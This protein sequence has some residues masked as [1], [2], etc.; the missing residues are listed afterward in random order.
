MLV[1]RMLGDWITSPSV[2]RGHA[3]VRV[4]APRAVVS[5]A[6]RA[7]LFWGFHEAQEIRYVNAYLTPD[8]PVVELG[9]SLGVVSAHVARRLNGARKLICVEANASALALARETILV[10]APGAEVVRISGAVDY[11]GNS[12]ASFI[13][14]DDLISSRL[15][16]TGSTAIR[17]RSITLSA[18]LAES[19]ITD[20]ALVCDVE[21]AESQILERDASSLEQCNI[22]IIELHAGGGTTVD[23]MAIEIGRL[24]FRCV[25][26]HGAV[27]VFVRD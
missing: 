11:I 5:D 17:V 20:Y 24:G 26:N 27:H 6:T 14:S 25:D 1:S 3:P 18:V 4:L 15:G 7:S 12:S 9:T 16:H 13:V 2:P 8:L 19:G 22:M 21:G 10:N 23:A